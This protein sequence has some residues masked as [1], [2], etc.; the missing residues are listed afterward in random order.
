M[1]L[2]AWAVTLT[3]EKH[4]QTFI[5]YFVCAILLAFYIPFVILGFLFTEAK[6]GFNTGVDFS[7]YAGK[8]F[9]DWLSDGR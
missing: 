3:Q 1:V 2:I 6:D 4:M 9:E 5:K 7:K 8:N